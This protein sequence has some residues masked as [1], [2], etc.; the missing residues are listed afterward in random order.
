MLPPAETRHGWLRPGMVALAILGGV[1][2]AWVFGVYDYLRLENLSRLQRW[3]GGLGPWAPILYM[4]GYVIL[5]LVFVPALPLTVLAG[6]AFGPVWGTLYAWI[7]A[8]LSA[9]L[10]FLVAR[11]GARE[12]VERWVARS[13]RVAR[14]DEAVARHGWRIL[15]FT[16]LLPVFPFNMQNYAYG[17]TGIGFSTYV[18]VSAV[19]MLPGT[20][21][22]T[23][24]GDAL[25][26]GGRSYAWLALYLAIATLLLVVLR[27]VPKRLGRRSGVTDGLI[28]R[29]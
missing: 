22:F 29:K 10:A 26:E 4:A 3:V 21:A 12:M 5:E 7:G 1:V 11:H 13:P 23:L 8:T 24:A 17:L 25:A 15:A 14:I 19:F 16:R 18:L 20:A 27:I 6:I 28:G 2:L 9:A